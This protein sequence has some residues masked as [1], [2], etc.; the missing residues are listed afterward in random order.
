MDVCPR[1]WKITKMWVF[2]PRNFQD[3]FQQANSFTVSEALFIKIQASVE[4]NGV[5][6]YECNLILYINLGMFLI[7]LQKLFFCGFFF[8][9][10]I[11]RFP[12]YSTFDHNFMGGGRF[13]WEQR[14]FPLCQAVFMFTQG[15]YQVQGSGGPFFI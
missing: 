14:I 12:L 3:D 9:L 1:N 13:L 5:D 8:F 10:K 4:Q 6:F 2:C 7:Y 15:V 11:F